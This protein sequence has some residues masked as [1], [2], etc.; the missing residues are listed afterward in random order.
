MQTSTGCSITHLEIIHATEQALN[1]N[2]AEKRAPC[3]HAFFYFRDPAC[4]PDASR[5]ATLSESE[6]SI[7]RDTFFER[8]DAQAGALARLKESVLTRFTGRDVVRTYRGQWDERAENPEDPRLRGR[9]A[10]QI[11]RAHV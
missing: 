9:L 4:V 1:R 5:L 3:E 10:S 2:E 7:Y 11:G 8:D 6:R